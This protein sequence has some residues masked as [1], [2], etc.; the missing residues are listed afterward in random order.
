MRVVRWCPASE[1]TPVDEPPQPSADPDDTGAALLAA[2]TRRRPHLDRAR[3]PHRGAGRRT[4]RRPRARRVATSRPASGNATSQ[5]G[6]GNARLG[7]LRRGSDSRRTR[8]D[9]RQFQA[10]CTRRA[11]LAEATAKI[12]A[13]S[14]LGVRR[15]LRTS[16]IGRRRFSF[17]RAGVV[18]GRSRGVRR[19]AAPRRRSAAAARGHQLR[20]PPLSNFGATTMPARPRGVTLAPMHREPRP[21]PR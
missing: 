13:A 18:G 5:V 11:A 3:Q 2:G 16:V 4:Q 12:R 10:G 7:S 9:H 20:S 17:R 8:L 14:V 6:P 1:P 15:A 19:H 21:D